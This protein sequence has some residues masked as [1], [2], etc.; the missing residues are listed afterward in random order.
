MPKKKLAKKV[1]PKDKKPRKDPRVQE[2]YETTV[3][4]K[5]PTR[6]LVTQKV[7]VKRMKP[8]SEQATL[9]SAVL[10]GDEIDRLEEKDNGLSMYDDDVP[11]E[12]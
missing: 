11:G 8:L 10:G 7:K 3:T 6:G 9:S 4:F 1:A 2:V 5:C 12:E